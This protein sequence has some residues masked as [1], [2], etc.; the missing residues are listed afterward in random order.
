MAQSIFAPGLFQ[1]QTA[2]ITGGGT[3]IG[4]A[5]ALE[6]TSLG[7][8]VAIGS[9]KQENVDAGLAAL[10]ALGLAEPLGQVLDIRDADACQAFAKDV[11]AKTGR[12]DVLVNNAGGQ[13]P[14]PA[15][16]LSPRGFEAVIRNNLIGLFNMTQAVANA[17]MIPAR[18]G[19]I[20]NVIADVYRGFPG[21]AHTGAARAGVDNLTKSLAVEWARHGIRVNA[22]AP[23]TIRSS[24]TTQYG[25]A[26]L[27]LSRAATPVKRLGTVEEVSRVIV[28]LA[29]AANDFVTGSTYYI[30]GG[31]S[32]WGD[33]WPIEEPQG[34]RA[35]EPS[36]AE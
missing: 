35:E 15:E 12:I 16:Q 25:E 13:F 4:L 14:C 36:G 8:T 30:D 24:G 7:A 28:F 20:V 2:L 18:R 29:S 1:G 6:L 22:C 9:R 27:E 5:A 31:G 26:T 19:R 33:V 32:L 21:M 11:L 10:R 23:G 3:G 34:E 17:A